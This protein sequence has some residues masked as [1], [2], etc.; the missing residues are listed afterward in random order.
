MHAIR[1]STE[2]RN[3]LSHQVPI[4]LPE[5]LSKRTKQKK[6]SITSHSNGQYIFQRREELTG[7]AIREYRLLVTPHTW[8]YAA[9][10]WGCADAQATPGQRFTHHFDTELDAEAEFEG[11]DLSP[12]GRI[13]AHS[14]IICGAVADM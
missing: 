8:P 12:D 2:Y 7:I 3:H 9:G 10:E 14:A 13:L 6:F 5:R 4:R 11:T 1:K